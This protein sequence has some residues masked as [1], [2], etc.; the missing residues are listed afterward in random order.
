[1]QIHIALQEILD[2]LNKALTD[3]ELELEASNKSISTNTTS[4]ISNRKKDVTNFKLAI[5]QV[6]N[7]PT[8]YDTILEN[9][10]KEAKVIKANI[11]QIN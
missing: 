1:M 7:D 10:K 4:L 11:D 3:K 9:F 6:A 5:K 8:L 2:E